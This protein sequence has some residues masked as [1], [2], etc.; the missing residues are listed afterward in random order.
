MKR[1]L[2][3]VYGAFGVLLA[4]SIYVAFASHEGLVE[5][6]YSSRAQRYFADKDAERAAGVSIEVDGAFRRGEGFA[7]VS[8][9]TGKGPLRG[10][11]VAL[12]A[13]HAAGPTLDRTFFLDER[14]PG[15]YAGPVVLPAAGWWFMDLSVN[16]GPLTARRSWTV[17]ASPAKPPG[18]G[19]GGRV[20][21]GPATARAGRYT[22]TLEITPRPIRPMREL[23]FTVDI[24]GYEGPAP[25]I[26]LSMPGMTMPPNTVT[27]SRGADGTYRGTGAIVRCRSGRKSWTAEVVLPGGPKAAFPFEH[28]D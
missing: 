8:A 6:H 18:E 25:R 23:V 28:A 3:G 22:I 12:A 14:E 17:L 5:D 4:A 20:E 10:A 21:Q 2:A 9:R 13:R 11:R 24:P 16:R 19:R 1:F 26:E 27:L 7:A 15:R